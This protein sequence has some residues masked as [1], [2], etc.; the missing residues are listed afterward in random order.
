MNFRL[1]AGATLL[2][3][4]LAACDSSQKK[5]TSDGPQWLAGDIHTHTF[6]TD[7]FHPESQVVHNAFERSGLDFMANSE[8]GG[9]SA[10]DTTGAAWAGGGLGD[11]ASATR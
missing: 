10:R 7:G 2:A 4:A 1:A 11:T 9:T 8:H 6:L 3:F 5:S